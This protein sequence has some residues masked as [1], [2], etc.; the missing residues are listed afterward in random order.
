MITV[1]I[2]GGVLHNVGTDYNSFCYLKKCRYF[3]F[4][5]PILMI[6]GIITGTVVLEFCP[7]FFIKEQESILNYRQH[8][9]TRR[10]LL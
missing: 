6:A 2:I 1:A 5:Y 4:M 3:Y 8:G 9:F 7:I 10:F